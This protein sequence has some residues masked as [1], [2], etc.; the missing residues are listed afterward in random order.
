VNPFTELLGFREEGAKFRVRQFLAVDIGQDLDALQFQIVHDM[1]E[2]AHRDLRL[3][4][5]DDA[6]PDETIRSA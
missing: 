3:L 5:G 2:F 4:Q 6:E 1:V